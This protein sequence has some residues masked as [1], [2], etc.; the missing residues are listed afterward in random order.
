VTKLLARLFSAV[1][2]LAVPDSVNRPNPLPEP[3]YRQA[4][5]WSNAIRY[6][7]LIRHAAVPVLTHRRS[8]QTISPSDAYILL[9]AGV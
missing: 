9:S 2:A 1:P 7:T 3:S 6:I 8:G 4:G 5:R